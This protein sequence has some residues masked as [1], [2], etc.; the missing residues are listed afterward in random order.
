MSAHF[1]VLEEAQQEQL[2]EQICRDVLLKAANEP[3]G[4]T[5][6]E[7]TAIIPLCGDFVFQN[8]LRDAIRR[9]GAI[10]PWIDS[11]R[12]IETPWPSFRKRSAL[13]RPTRWRR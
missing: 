9:G 3:E 2:L 10:V 7:L 6:R 12:G 5:G 11:A 1:S 4:A 13:I 8:A